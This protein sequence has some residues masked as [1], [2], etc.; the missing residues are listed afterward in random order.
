MRLCR[1]HIRR[2]PE[3]AD[4]K[5][6]RTDKIP[7]EK[8]EIKDKQFTLV[9]HCQPFAFIDAHL[10]EVIWVVCFDIKDH[11]IRIRFDNTGNDEQQT[12]QEREQ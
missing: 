11:R 2:D 10:P 12:P 9:T 6:Q 4:T 3:D 7:A 1:F 8:A 5:A